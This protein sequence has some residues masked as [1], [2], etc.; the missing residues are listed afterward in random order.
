MN[1]W[2][3]LSDYLLEKIESFNDDSPMVGNRSI[4]KKQYWNSQM[5][6]CIKYSG[7]ALPIRTKDILL[8]RIKRNF[9]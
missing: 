9:R 1:T 4:T 6:E 3:E 5:G 8:K 7:E 2:D